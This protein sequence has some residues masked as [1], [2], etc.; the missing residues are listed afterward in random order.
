MSRT[1]APTILTPT[2]GSPIKGEAKTYNRPLRAG[3]RLDAHPSRGKGAFLGAA[4]PARPTGPPWRLRPKSEPSHGSR[5]CAGSGE[6]APQKPYCLR[7]P[8]KLQELCFSLSCQ[9]IRN[10]KPKCQQFS[11]NF[12]RPTI[13]SMPSFTTPLDIVVPPIA[14]LT[15]IPA[16]RFTSRAQ[17]VPP[18]VGN[19]ASSKRV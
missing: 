3:T 7:I 10:E 11:E 8:T 15:P 16:A 14:A 19:Q 4:S 17:E 12:F 18:N 5:A 6:P 9:D 1:P 2:A 13:S